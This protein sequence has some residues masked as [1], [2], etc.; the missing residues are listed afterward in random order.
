MTHAIPP[1]SPEAAGG[2]APKEHRTLSLWLGLLAPAVLWAAALQTSY[3]LVPYAQ[4]HPARL[5]L[6]HLASAVYLV[7]TILCGVVCWIEW[8]RVGRQ[9]PS[10]F[11]GG[12]VGRTRFLAALGILSAALFAVALIAQALASFFF[13]P[14]WE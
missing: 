4:R 14:F 9:W 11:V 5:W 2:P 8:G 7:L 6:L 10:D 3:V 13:S 1:T 12:G